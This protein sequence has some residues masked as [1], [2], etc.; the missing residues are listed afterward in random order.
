MYHGTI[1]PLSATCLAC[2]QKG[3]KK[4]STQFKPQKNEAG[5]IFLSALPEDLEWD[6]GTEDVA[7]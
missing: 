6:T 5:L 3:A 4:K 2:S 7:L 1:S